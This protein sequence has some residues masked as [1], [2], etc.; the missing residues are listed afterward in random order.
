[1]GRNKTRDKSQPDKDASSAS[2]KPASDKTGQDAGQAASDQLG[3][4]DWSERKRPTWR[5]FPGPRMA[6]AY[7]RIAIERVAYAELI[8]HSKGTLDKE[9]CGVLVGDVCEDD[10]GLFVHIKDIIRGAAADQSG[11]HVT[12]TQETW[13]IIHQTMEERFPK[14]LI[15][16]WYH[17]HPGYGVEFSEMDR[18]IQ[19]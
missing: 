7:L 18:F 1:M 11:T 5:S 16:G 19:K 8:A 14:L 9:V 13:N 15:V 3:L 17:S 4:S 6:D 2:G 10:E 12:Y